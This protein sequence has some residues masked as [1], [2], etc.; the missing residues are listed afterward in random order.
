MLKIEKIIFSGKSRDEVIRDVVTIF[1]LSLKDAEELVKTFVQ[2]YIKNPWDSEKE[3]VEEIVIW[4]EYM[5][6]HL[7][8][9][10]P[11]LISIFYEIKKYAASLEM[12]LDNPENVVRFTSHM[13]EFHPISDKEMESHI[14]IMNEWCS[15]MKNREDKNKSTLDILSNTSWNKDNEPED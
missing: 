5:S 10:D 15:F 11:S 13:R 2:D 6:K 12:P 7:K 14:K 1:G 9:E 4:I 8:F 3:K